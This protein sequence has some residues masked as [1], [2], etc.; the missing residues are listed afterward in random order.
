VLL[1]QAEPTRI[2]LD[3]LH[4]KLNSP[5][6]AKVKESLMDVGFGADIGGMTWKPNDLGDAEISVLATYAGRASDMGK[7][8]EN[9]QINTD[10]NL[11]LQ[12]LAGL[13]VDSHMETEIFN[14]IL[15]Y[16]SFPRDMFSGSSQRIDEME[17]ALQAG[18][19]AQ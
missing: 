10:S 6:Y 11:R 1:G 8:M 9:A 7:W 17:M 15:K 19:R 16:Y 13:S 3:K 12:Y 14:G 5:E 4:E 2:D 18:K